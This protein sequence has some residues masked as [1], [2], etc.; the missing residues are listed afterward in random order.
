MIYTRRV[1]DTGNQS[2]G[3]VFLVDRMWPRGVKK[4]DLEIDRWSK[5]V[6]PSNELRRWFHKQPEKWEQFKSKYYRELDGRPEAWNQILDTAKDEDI[7]LLY[8]SRNTEHNNAAALKSYL[9]EKLKE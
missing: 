3:K 2:Q 4:S 5:E 1:Y 7:T 9:E 6:A 8:S